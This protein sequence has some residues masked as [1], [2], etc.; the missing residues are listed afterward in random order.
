[1]R[2]STLTRSIVATLGHSFLRFANADFFIDSKLQ[3]E[4]YHGMA[5]S[6]IAAEV[7]IANNAFSVLSSDKFTLQQF[8]VE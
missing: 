1:M 7:G 8:G 5:Q 4:G 2:T 3:L 6:Y